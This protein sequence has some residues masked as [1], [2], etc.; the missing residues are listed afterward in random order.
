MK[1]IP[2]L[3]E[4]RADQKHVNNAGSIVPW[5]PEAFHARFLVFVKSYWKWPARKAS[6]PQRHPFDSAEPI[7][8]Q[9]L[10]QNIQNMDVLLIG[11]L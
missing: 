4:E 5:V 9:N 11:S 10:Y 7:T 8:T 3:W 1:F 2:K 6:G